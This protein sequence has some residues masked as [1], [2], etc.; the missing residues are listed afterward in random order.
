M[1]KDLAGK[2]VSVATYAL[3][4]ELV[5][6]VVFRYCDNAYEARFW[7]VGRRLRRPTFAKPGR[8]PA[9]PPPRSVRKAMA[10]KAIAIA[11]DRL[12]SA[13]KPKPAPAGYP[14]LDFIQPE[15][16]KT[17][18]ERNGPYRRQIARVGGPHKQLQLF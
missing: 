18:A 10:A 7:V 6:E 16:A 17:S 13:A 3:D 1:K 14:C 5:T 2:P 8:G 4:N 9:E 15:R 11:I 12:A